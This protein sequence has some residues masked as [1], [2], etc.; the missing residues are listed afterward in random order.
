LRELK[1]EVPT[2][3][4]VV[5]FDDIPVAAFLGPALTTVSVPKDELGRRA[6]GMLRQLLVD[7]EPAA[8]ER[9]PSSLVVRESTAPPPAF[10]RT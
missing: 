10:T 2:A 4:S 9:L 6:G 7:G 1:L 3:L 5:G 8:Q